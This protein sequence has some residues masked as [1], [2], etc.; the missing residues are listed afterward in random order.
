[1]LWVHSWPISFFCQIVWLQLMHIVVPLLVVMSQKCIPSKSIAGFLFLGVYVTTLC[2]SYQELSRKSSIKVDLITVTLK[3][4][5]GKTWQQ[6]LPW[7]L[8]TPVLGE[9]LWCQKRQWDEWWS[10]H[11]VLNG[12]I[13]WVTGISN[14]WYSLHYC[15]H[16]QLYCAQTNL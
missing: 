3:S 14:I 1:M 16:V 4:W 15:E 9:W 12:F 13:A 6:S 5:A 2:K 10:G 7:F 11:Q 8:K